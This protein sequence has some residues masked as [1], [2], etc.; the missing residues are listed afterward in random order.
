[1]SS[2]GGG[3]CF[4]TIQQG[5]DDYYS[6]IHL[7]LDGRTVSS[8]VGKANVFL[9]HY[10]AV[11]RLTFLKEER[12]RNRECKA[13]LKSPSA[14]V[15]ASRDFSI[16]ELDSA[17]AKTKTKGAAG[18]DDIPATFLKA[19]GPQARSQLLHIFNTSFREGF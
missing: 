9:S 11:S 2:V 5:C 1:M 16:T 4:T 3:P 14:D 7:I 8:D 13:M 18:P 6:T 17:I 15:E 19:L 10:A 12:A